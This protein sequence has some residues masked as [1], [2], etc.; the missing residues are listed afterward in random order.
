MLTV[1]M[2]TCCDVPQVLDIQKKMSEVKTLVDESWYLAEKVVKGSVTKQQYLDQS[3]KAESK[4]EKL[5][6]DIESVVQ[7]L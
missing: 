3:K 6:Q 2:L 1:N 7:T 4:M 5:M